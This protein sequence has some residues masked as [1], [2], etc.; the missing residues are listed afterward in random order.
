MSQ[1]QDPRYIPS[2]RSIGWRG[3][4]LL[5][6]LFCTGGFLLLRNEKSVESCLNVYI[7][8]GDFERFE[9]KKKETIRFLSLKLKYQG[10]R[11]QN[12]TCRHSIADT[13]E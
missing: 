6:R 9:M 2:L 10:Q 11:V 3:R 4:S 1:P 7:R 12:Q 5:L 8:I 13:I